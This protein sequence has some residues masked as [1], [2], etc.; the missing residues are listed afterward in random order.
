MNKSGGADIVK[1][2]QGITRYSFSSNLILRP[3]TGGSWDILEPIRKKHPELFVPPKSP[4]VL[5][6]ATGF[7]T[8]LGGK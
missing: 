4:K 3:T 5:S 1:K 2:E 6:G 8:L 7:D